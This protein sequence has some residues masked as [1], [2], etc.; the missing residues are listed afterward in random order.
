MRAAVEMRGNS[1]LLKALRNFT[2]DLEKQMRHELG[3]VL[4]PVVKAAQSYVKSDAPMRGWRPRVFHEGY[5]PTY[6]AQTIR[7]NI[8]YH[9]GVIDRSRISIGG[10]S[11]AGH[12]D[13]FTSIAQILNKSPAGA[14][15]ET[16]HTPQKWVGPKAG[17]SHKGVSRSNWKGAGA[18][19]IRNLPP[20]YQTD[21]G[22][23]RLI[24]RAWHDTHDA[25]RK[26]AV[27]TIDRTLAE[28]YKRNQQ[29]S[30]S[31]AA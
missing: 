7:H 8:V 13:N 25:T 28:F 12:K 23:G 2:G 20:T 5:F 17:G 14:I 27:V 21:Q 6:N 22:R 30:F 19:F 15:Y 31:R 26:I 29:H 16:A 11:F 18:Q 10:G 1:D 9:Y 3:A 24:Y 4:K